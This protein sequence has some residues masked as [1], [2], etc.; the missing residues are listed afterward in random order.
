M[1]LQYQIQ[2]KWLKAIEKLILCYQI[3]QDWASKM[4]Y[5]HLSPEEIYSVLRI[6][7]LMVI[8]L[9]HTNEDRIEYLYITACISGQKLVLEKLPVFSSRIYYMIMKCIESNVAIHQKC[10][11][12]KQFMFWHDRLGH[13]GSIMMRWIIENTYRHPLKNLN[14]LLP[15]EN[16]CDAYSQGK[17]ITKPS[18]SKVL[19][20]SPSFLERIQGDICGPIH[21]PCGPFRY[22]MVL[23][24]ASSKWSHVCLLSSR[25]IAFARLIEEII[26]LRI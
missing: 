2:K 8:I 19:I 12:P 17:L 10:S 9:K 7:V 23:I 5:I 24:D 13:P 25:N 1:S 20:E 18:P 14:I 15:S 26:K 22:F 6:Y 3:T 16:P 21:P 4:H 11:D